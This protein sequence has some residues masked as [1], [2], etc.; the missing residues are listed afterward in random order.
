MALLLCVV[1]V[2]SAQTRRR[3]YVRVLAPS[4]LLL[5]LTVGIG[6]AGCGGGGASGGGTG[7]PPPTGTAAGTYTVTVT[8]ISG[9]LTHTTALTLVV[10]WQGPRALHHEPNRSVVLARQRNRTAAGSSTSYF[11]GARYPPFWKKSHTCFNAAL[12]LLM[13]W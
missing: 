13:N 2:P 5:L 8:A 1:L 7:S 10:Q 12:L 9:A 3:R 6:L 11:S 4:V